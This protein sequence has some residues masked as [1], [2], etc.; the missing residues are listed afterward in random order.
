MALLDILEFPDPRLRTTAKPVNNV[1]GKIAG[2][3]DQMLDAM[4]AVQL[5]LRDKTNADET[6]T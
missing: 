5:S 1:D 3:A 2:L 4:Y 6:K